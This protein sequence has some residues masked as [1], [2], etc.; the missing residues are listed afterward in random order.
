ML[1]SIGVE[2]VIIGHSERRKIF[3]E[4]DNIISGKVSEALEKGLIIIFCCGENLDDRNGNDHFK[5]VETQLLNGLFNINADQIKECIIAY[6]PVWAIGTGV[7]ASTEQAE[8]MHSFIRKK[9]GEKYGNETAMNISILYG[10]SVSPENSA[11]LFT[12]ENVDGALVGG[13]SLKADSFLSIISS[14]N[15]AKL[16]TRNGL[17]RS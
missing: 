17:Y 7:N 2:Y 9:I 6:E 4:D 13:A 15:Q 16:K 12:S 5:I 14:I 1:A 8:E 11:E 3:N 10:G